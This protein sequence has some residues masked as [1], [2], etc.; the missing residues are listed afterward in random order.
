MSV[1]TD[2]TLPMPDPGRLQVVQGYGPGRFRVSEVE[3]AGPILV[4]PERC[5]AWTAASAAD[6]APDDLGP[7][8]AM[9]PPVE[10]LVLGC[11]LKASFVPPARRAALK[12]AGI[13]L[14][15]MDTGAACRTYNVLLAEGRRVAAALIP[16]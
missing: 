5:V 4:T 9:V 15:V 16:V 3:H 14:E 2:K 13:A 11:G 8:L 10:V 12:A 7:A 1:P 6:I